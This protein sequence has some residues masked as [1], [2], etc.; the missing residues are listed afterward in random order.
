[1]FTYEV[2][3]HRGKDKGRT[4]DGD[5]KSYKGAGNKEEECLRGK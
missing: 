2:S 5:I 3:E 4:K 1:M